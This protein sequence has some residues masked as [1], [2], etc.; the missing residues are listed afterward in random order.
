MAPTENRFEDATSRLETLVEEMESG[1]LTLETAL[2]KFS[3]GVLLFKK[4]RA[5]LDEAEKKVKVLMVQ[6][7]GEILED[8]QDKEDEGSSS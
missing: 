6:K 2:E 1:G 4:C 3:E 8:F 5:I 7:D